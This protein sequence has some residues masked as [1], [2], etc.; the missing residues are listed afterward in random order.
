MEV[1]LKEIGSDVCA[2]TEVNGYENEIG[3]IEIIANQWG[4]GEVNGSCTM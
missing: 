4:S 3:I 2:N 1:V